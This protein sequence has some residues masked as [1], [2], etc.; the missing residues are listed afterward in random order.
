MGNE[1]N[2]MKSILCFRA[3]FSRIPV[4]N[5]A[6]CGII[7]PTEESRK[8]EQKKMD[9]EKLKWKIWVMKMKLHENTRF[10]RRATSPVTSRLFKDYILYRERRYG[11]Y[12]RNVM[13]ICI[14]KNLTGD[15]GMIFYVHG[16]GFTMGDKIAYF[17][18]IRKD[19]KAGYVCASLNYRYASEE[20]NINDML[21]DITAAVE[22]ARKTAEKRGIRLHKMLMTG[23]SAGAHLA[24]LYAYSKVGDAPVQPA[25]VVSYCGSADLSLRK[26]TFET[27]IGKPENVCKLFGNLADVKI[28]PDTFDDHAS[29]L[30]R[31]SAIS[32][33][34]P[35]T[36]PTVIC[37]GDL[38][39]CVDI[40]QAEH[41]E[42]ALAANNVTHEFVRYP[43]S[44]HG[45]SDDPDQS[46]RAHSL[47]LEYAERYVRP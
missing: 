43:N 24:L 18:Q 6:G 28:T 31:I 27:G 12:S 33:V 19:Q 45:L 10:L 36:V 2:G 38:D 35:E 3:F 7:F 40:E 34:S 5:I 41:L 44:G 32:Y 11:K 42:A 39:N 13:D 30:R 9:R 37:H 23:G 46:E 20:T 17:G 4:P 14:P 26:M 47:M 21:D 8:G 25:A 1:K 15:A 22:C 16:G 29:D